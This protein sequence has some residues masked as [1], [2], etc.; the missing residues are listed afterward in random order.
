MALIHFDPAMLLNSETLVLLKKGISTTM[1]LFAVSWIAGLTL[2]IALAVMRMTKSAIL[3]AAAY[4]VIVYHQNTPVLLNVL[5]WYFALPQLLPREWRL[6]LNAYNGE[7]VFAFVALTLNTASY[8]AEDIRSGVNSVSAQQYE[9]ARAIGLTSL[10]AMKDVILPQALRASIPQLVN[11]SLMLFKATSIGMTVGLLEL[12]GVTRQISSDTFRTIEIFAISS[13][14][15]FVFAFLI[16][17]FG[18][19]AERLWPASSAVH[20]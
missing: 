9:A 7:F 19:V 1:L 13:A 3:R 11:Q 6:G 8:M 18:V 10:Q 20:D 4:V 2:G 5:I 12:A 15:Y 14:I 16:M 17:S